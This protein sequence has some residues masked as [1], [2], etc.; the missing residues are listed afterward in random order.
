MFVCIECWKVLDNTFV[1]DLDE[2]MPCPIRGCGGAIFN[3]DENFIG[4]I[5]LLNEKGYATCFC[6]SGHIWDFPGSA[7]PYIAFQAD[8]E[9][10]ELE[11]LPKGWKFDNDDEVCIIRAVYRASDPVRMQLAIYEGVNVLAEW[12]FGLK[13]KDTELSNGNIA[14]Q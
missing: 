13:V 2:G 3:I 10:Q 8:V 9:K 7:Q 11:P 14:T 1:H 6:C 12:A 5:Q 4:V